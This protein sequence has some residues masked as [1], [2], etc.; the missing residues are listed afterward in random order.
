MQQRLSCIII[1][2]DDLDRLA[3]EAEVTL[4]EGL[5]MIGSFASPIEA[6][7]AM[8]VAKPDV[9]F[10][11][12]DMPELNGLDFI[13]CISALNTTNVMISSHPEYA[14]EGFKLSV[15]D[16][17]LKPLET[18]R[19]EHTIK[20][21]YDF[22]ALKNKANAYDVLFEKEKIIFKEGHSMVNINANEVVYLEA[23]GDYTKIVTDK[24]AH[25][26]LTT[27]GSFMEALPAGKFVRIHRSYIVPTKNIA[28][29]SAKSIAITNN[30]VLPIG[31]TYLKEIKHILEK[32]VNV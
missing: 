14:L 15:F 5:K 2:D 25:L 11:D 22:A 20:R 31:K 26:T 17:I 7:N 24:K 13:R 19:F 30:M 29:Y 1:D 8:Q 21:I 12:I 32:Y 9:L 23:Y 6:F 16:F 4:Q 18:E 3:V 10:L 27:L 28:S